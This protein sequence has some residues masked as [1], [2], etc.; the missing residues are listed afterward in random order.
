MV[1]VDV[2]VD[3]N[4]EV[5]DSGAQCRVRHEM[6]VPQDILVQKTIYIS[7][8][9]SPNLKPREQRIEYRVQSTYSSEEV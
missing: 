4:V 7:L 5:A 3:V 6:K 9:C 1:D 2:N 8:P